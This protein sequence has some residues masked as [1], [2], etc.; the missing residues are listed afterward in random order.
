[1]ASI[2]SPSGTA[3]GEAVFSLSPRDVSIITGETTTAPSVTMS[4][5][6]FSGNPKKKNMDCEFLFH[7][8]LLLNQ[9]I[10]L[11]TLA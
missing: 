6:K 8:S 4:Q 11:I 2:V 3:D 5:I 1:M 7:L 10:R 9:I